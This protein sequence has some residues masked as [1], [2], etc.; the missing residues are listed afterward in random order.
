MNVNLSRRCLSMLL[1]LVMLFTMMPTNIIA[2]EL[3]DHDHEEAVSLVEVEALSVSASAS[4][5]Y[6]YAGEEAVTVTAKIAGGMAPYEV[7]LQAVKNG[8]VVFTDSKTTESN[9]VKLSYKPVSWG[10]YELV[11]TAHDALH[12]QDL[13]T[14]TLAVAEHDMENEAAWAASV[15]G[16]SVSSDWAKSLVSVAKT[17]VGYEES[18]KDFVIKSGEKQG[19]S[20]YGAWFGTPYTGWNNAFL[21]FVAEYAKVPNDA[22]LSGSSYRSWVNGMSAKGAYMKDGYT[23]KAGDIA[24]L[25][26]SRAALVESV[27][28]ANVTVIE[29]DVNGAV[30]RK[31]Y[32]ISKVA[33]FGN[34]GLM[35]GLHNGTATAVPTAAPEATKAPE[36]G[37]APVVTAAPTA[38]PAPT[39]VPEDE[40]LVFQA[41][42]TPRPGVTAKPKEDSNPL[43]NMG[44]AMDQLIG[45]LDAAATAI[46]M[47]FSE[48]YYLMQAEMNALLEKYLGTATPTKAEIEAF[49]EGLELQEMYYILLEIEELREYAS[50]IGISDYEG[51]AAFEASPMFNSFRNTMEIKYEMLTVTRATLYPVE[52]IEVTN[53]TDKGTSGLYHKVEKSFWGSS[54]ATITIKNTADYAATVEFGYTVT[55]DD[56]AT[57][58]YVKFDT[59]TEYYTLNNGGASQS[60]VG[61][62][63]SYMLAAGASITITVYVKSNAINNAWLELY[64]KDFTHT[65]ANDSSKV[66]FIYDE[67]LGLM[68]VA[69]E[70]IGSGAYAEI[71]SAGAVLAATPASG[72]S[73]LGWIDDE[74][75]VRSTETTFTLIPPNEMTVQAVFTKN[76]G[77]STAW[78][79]VGGTHLYN[80]LNVAATAA[81]G[82][83]SKTVVLMNNATLPAGEYTIPAGVTM[84]IPFDAANTLYT[85][86]PDSDAT[87]GFLSAAAVDYIQPTYFR[88]LTME[89][90]AHITIDGAMSLSAKHHAVAGGGRGAGAPNGPVS[91]VKMESGST[92]A[93]NSGA[94]LYAWGFITGAGEV[95]AEAGATVYENFQFEDFRGGTATTNMQS[96]VFPLSHY[97]VQNIECKLKIKAGAQVKTFTSIVMSRTEV[98]L[99]MTFIAG[100]GDSAEAM[101]RISGG[102]VTKQYSGG[103]MVVDAY[104]AT[105]GISKMVISIQG[106][107]LDTSKYNLPI[108]GNVLVRV[109]NGSVLDIRQNIEMHPGATIILDEGAVCNMSGNVYL[110]AEEDWGP[111]SCSVNFADYKGVMFS[112]TTGVKPDDTNVRGDAKVVVN[113]RISVQQLNN[114][115][116]AAVYRTEHG[117][118]I[119]SDGTGEIVLS[120]GT[121]TKTQ[122]VRQYNDNGEKLEYLDIPVYPAW[123]TNNPGA[124]STHEVPAYLDTADSEL[125]GDGTYYYFENAWHKGDAENKAC[126]PGEPA[127]CTTDCNCIFCGKVVEAAYHSIFAADFCGEKACDRC[128]QAV[129]GSKPHVEAATGEV[130]TPATCYSE[131]VMSFTCTVCNQ[132]ARTE[133]VAKVPHTFGGWMTDK[134]ATCTEA[135]TKHREC[136]TC[137]AESGDATRVE[138]G[139]IDAFGHNYNMVIGTPTCAVN[140]VLTFTCLND[141]NHVVVVTVEDYDNN[142]VNADVADKVTAELIESI[143]AKGHVE[144]TPATCTEQAV[145]N[146][147]GEKYGDPLGHL[148]HLTLAEPTCSK[149]GYITVVCDREGCTTTFASID[150]EDSI[151]DTKLVEAVTALLAG[152]DAY[153]TLLDLKTKG[154]S[155]GDWNVT[156]QPTCTESGSRERT[157]TVEGCGYKE[158]EVVS[159]TGHTYIATHNEKPNGYC[160]EQGS[161]TLTC[162]C[163]D[164]YTVTTNVEDKNLKAEDAAW[165]VENQAKTEH[166]ALTTTRVAPTCTAAG[167]TETACTCGYTTGKVHAGDATGHQYTFVVSAPDCGVAGEIAFECINSANGVDCDV[168]G[169]VTSADTLSALE[170]SFPGLSNTLKADETT[171]EYAADLSKLAAKD[172]VYEDVWTVKTPADCENA[173]VEHRFCTNC[174]EGEETRPINALGHEF[175]YVNYV[176]HTEPTCKN[177]AEPAY[178]TYTYKCTNGGCAETVTLSYENWDDE[179]YAGNVELIAALK[180]LDYKDCEASENATAEVVTPAKCEVDAIYGYRCDSCGTFVYTW[181]ESGTALEHVPGTEATCTADQTCTREGC[182]KV[183]EAAKGHALV[184]AMTKVPDCENPGE[185]T[186]SCSRNCG[187]YTAVVLGKDDVSVDQDILKALGDKGWS[188]LAETL[189]ATGHAYADTWTQVENADGTKS[190]KKVCANDENHVL[191]DACAGGTATCEAAAVCT[192][193]SNS[194]GSSLGHAYGDTWTQVENAEGTK[195]H[196]K[197]CANDETHVLM[198]TCAGGTAT[199]E[200]AAVCTVCGNSYGDPLG[201]AYGEWTQTEDGKHHT[202]VCANDNSH[203][204][205]ED[206]YGTDAT[207]EKPA[208]CDVCKQVFVAASGHAYG[209]WT[210]VTEPTCTAEGSKQRVCSKDSTHVETDTI[211]AMGHVYE[212]ALTE[213]K[214]EVDGHITVTCTRGDITGL[215]LN[216]NSTADEQLYPGLT[217]ALADAGYSDLE[218]LLKHQGH[219]YT[220]VTKYPTCTVDGYI[221]HTCDCGHEYTD[222]P[223]GENFTELAK[224]GH[225]YQ[226]V[227]KNPT[228]TVDGYVTVTCTE[229]DYNKVYG[230]ADAMPSN[231]KEETAVKAALGTEYANLA[232]LAATDHAFT[233]WTTETEATC[234]TDGKKVSTCANGCGETAEEFIPAKGHTYSKEGE[235]APDC[236]TPGTITYSCDACEADVEN[237]TFV[238]EYGMKAENLPKNL[239]LEQSE[240]EAL[241]ATGHQNVTKYQ[242][243]AKSCLGYLGYGE[244]CEDCQTWIDEREQL[245]ADCEANTNDKSKYTAATCEAAGYYMYPC[246]WCKEYKF[247]VDDT[248]APAINHANAAWDDGT[249][250]TCE[251]IGYEKGL[252]CPDCETYREGHEEI[253]M[254]DHVYIVTS[255]GDRDCE[256]EGFQ[257]YTCQSGCKDVYE[258]RPSTY[259]AEE[260]PAEITVTAEMIEKLK[261]RGHSFTVKGETVDPECKIDNTG[262]DGYTVYKCEHCDETE[263]KDS[264]AWKHDFNLDAATCTEDKKC[265]S[266]QYVA[267]AKLGHDYFQNGAY[268]EAFCIKTVAAKCE[269]EGYKVYK[270][271]TCQDEKTVTLPALGHHMVDN[272]GTPATCTKEG[273]AAFSECDREGCE[274]TENERTIPAKGHDY[275]Q[276]GAYVE[277]FCTKTVNA[278]CTAD[279]YKVYEC[280]S[281]TDEEGHSQT[282][283]LQKLGHDYEGENNTY[284]GTPDEHKDA[285]CTEEGYDIFICD[286]CDENTEGHSTGKVNIVSATNHVGTTEEHG[287]QDSAC[288]A[289]GY[290]AGVYCTACKTWI[291]GHDVIEAKG[292]S[293]KLV[294]TAPNCELDG[295]IVV[296]CTACNAVN[297]TLNPESTIDEATYEGLTAKVNE[298]LAKGNYASLENLAAL[299]HDWADATCTAPK[300]CKREGCGETEGDKLGH[301]FT[302]KQETIAPDCNEDNTGTDGYTVYKCERCTETDKKDWKKWGHTYSLTAATCVEDRKCSDCGYVIE[303]ALGHDYPVSDEEGW[304][305]VSSATCNE[306]GSMKRVCA[307]NCGDYQT[308]VIPATEH[309]GTTENKDKQE[310][311][312]TEIGYEAGVYCTAC[313][314]WISGHDVIE[315]K[316]H[317]YKLVLTDPTCTADGSIAVS[318]ND[319]TGVMVALTPDSTINEEK[320]EG[321][322]ASVN[323]ALEK[324]GYESLEKL[325]ERGHDWADAT[326]TAPKT[327]QR[328]GCGMTTGTSLGHDW[329]AAT[330]TAPKTCQRE[331]CGVTE[332]DKLDHSYT[333]ADKVT[334]TCRTEGIKLYTCSC[335]DSYEENI[336]VNPDKH[337]GKY[338]PK[339][340]ATCTEPGKEAGRIC[341]ECGITLS[342]RGEI[343]A[344]GHSYTNKITTQPACETEGV[345][346]FTCINGSCGHT[347]TEA[348]P[349]TG[350]T[351]VPMKEVELNCEQNGSKGGKVCSVCGVITEQPV[352][353]ETEGHKEVDDEAVAP[354]C[355]AT[356]LTKGSHCSVCNKTIVEQEVVPANGHVKKVLEAVAPTCKETGLSEG[357]GCENCDVVFK[358]QEIVKATGHLNVETLAAVAPTCESTGLTE[359]SKCKDCGDVLTPQE[360]VPAEGHDWADATCTDPK[361]CKREG[362]GKTE[363]EALGH[364][365]QE[366]TCTDAKVCKVCKVTEGEALG[367]DWADA[368]CTEPKTCK[369][370]KVTEGEKLGHT[371]VKDEAKDATC[372][373]TGLTEGSHCSVCN[374]TLE[375]QNVISAKGH[376]S[377]TDAYQAPTCEATGLKEGSHCSVCNEV[378]VEQEVI[379]A[380]QHKYTG[381]ETKAPTCTEDGVMTYVCENDATHT[382]TETID[383]LGHDIEKHDAQKVTCT[384]IG[385]DAYENCKRE[386]CGYTTYVEIAATG[387]KLD[388]GTVTKQFT[389]TEAG[390]IVYAC[391]NDGCDYTEIEE[392]LA[393]HIAE[394]VPGYAPTCTETGLTEGSKCSVCGEILVKQEVITAT[395]KWE[396]VKVVIEATCTTEGKEDVRCTAEGCGVTSTIITPAKGHTEV[397]DPA[398]AKTCDKDGLTEGKHCSVCKAVLVKQEVVPASHEWS[399][400]PCTSITA[401][402]TECGKTN[403]ALLEH[404]WSDATCSAPATCSY[405]KRTKGSALPHTEV[406]DEEIP[407]MC[408]VTGL[409]AGKH[410]S[411]CGYVIAKQELIPA[412]GHNMEA[413]EAKK[414]TFTSVG[415]EAY[416][417]CTRCA[418]TTQVV[419]PALGEQTISSYSEFMKYL[420][421]LEQFAVAYAKENPGTDPVALVIKYIRTGVDRYNSGSWG[422]M[423]GYENAGFAKY[424]GEQEDILN[425]D[426]ENVEDMIKVTGLKNI[427]EFNLP[428]GQRTDIGHMFG[429]MDITY[430]N[431]GSVNHADVGGWAGDLVDLLSTADHTDHTDVIASAGGDFEKLVDAIR[432]ELLGHSFDHPDTFSKT[433][434]YGDLD[435]FYVM[436]NLDTEE[437]VAGDMTALFNS[438]FTTSLDDVDRAAY[439]MEHRLNGVATRSAVRDAVYT[440]YT[441]NNV[442]STLEGTRD[443]NSSDLTEMRQAVCYAFADYLCALAGDYVDVTDNPYLTVFQSE[444]ANLA[445]GISMEIH[446]ANSADNK[447]M[448]YYL[449]YGAVGR[450]DVTVLANY[451]ERHVTHWEMSRV[452]DQ[453]NTTQDLYSNPENKE[454]FADGELSKNEA[455]LFQENFNVITA[456]NG[457]GFN[458]GTGEP[459]GLLV[460]HGQE[461]HA[462]D[463]NG[464]FGMHKDGY[465]VI[466]TTEEY[467][468]KYKGQIE[469]AI[470]GFGTM[471]VKDGEL[472]ITAETDYYLNRASRTAIGI[473]ATGRVVFMVLDGRQEPWSCGGS[474]IEIA[475]IMKNAGCVQAIN[476]DGGGSTTFVA[477]QAG[478]DELSVVNRPSDGVSRSVSTGL[479]MISTAPSSTAFDHAVLE[480]DYNNA[481]VGSTV[482]MTAKG[483]SATGNVVD[484]P[485]GATWAVSDED[486]GSI[487]EN[488]VFTAKALGSVEV[489][490]VLDGTVLGYKTLNVVTPDQI[491]FTKE[492]LDGVYGSA[493][494]LPL[495]A[496]YEGK[497]VAFNAADIKFTL[498]HEG[499]GTIEGLK[500]KI[501]E[502][503]AI[504]NVTIT[505][506]LAAKSEINAKITVVL[507]KQGENSFDFDQATGG[508]RILAWQRTVSNSKTADNSV[509][510]I[511]DPNEDMVTSYVL[512]LDMTQIPMPARLQDLV[513]MLPGSDMEG[514]CAW[515]FL[516][517]LA[518]RISDLTEVKPQV[519]I[520]PNFDV[521]YSEL[522]VIND[523]FKLNKT[524]FDPETNTLTLTLNWVKQSQPIPVDTANPLCMVTGLKITPKADAK[525]ND[526]DQLK[527]INEG[528]VSYRV[529]MRASG[530]YSFC[531]K[532][533]NQKVFGLQPY[534]HPL[535]ESEKG[536]YF[537]DTYKEFS[538]TYTLVRSMKNG[539]Y[540]EDSGFRYYVDGVYLTGVQKADGLFYDFGEDGVNVGKKTYTGLHQMNGKT[541]Y[542][543]VGEIATGWNIIGDDWYL[544]NYSTGEGLNGKAVSGGIEYEFE[545]GRLLHGVWRKDS[546]GL[547]YYYGPGCYYSGWKVIEGEEY[548]FVKEYALTGTVPVQ[549]AHDLVH[550]WYE[551][552]EE[553]KKVG[554]AKDGLYWYKGERYYVV[555][556]LADR[557]GLYYIDGH[558]YNFTY[559]D[560]ATR[561]QTFWVYVTND[562]GMAEGMYRFGND[563]KMIM[564]TEIVKEDGVLYYYENG[565]RVD[566]KGMV[567]FNNN[568]YYIAGGGAAVVDKLYW[569]SKTNGLVSKTGM[570]LFDENGCMVRDTL[571]YKGTDGKLNYIKDGC[572]TYNAGLV[573]VDGAYYYIQSDGTAVTNTEMYISKTNGLMKAGTYAFGADGKMIIRLAGDAA[574][575]NDVDMDDVLALWAYLAGEDVKISLANADVNADGKIDANDALLI[576]QYVSGWDVTLK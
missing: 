16:A 259:K 487:D 533:E 472:A 489:R 88:T 128:G 196:K 235:Q 37:E 427:T 381:T 126:T 152:Y 102:Y 261:A 462:I 174:N 184:A 477:R 243:E 397:I 295:S 167:Y 362:C 145:C 507:F 542:I 284:V 498:S 165:L 432:F 359:G 6:V 1:V 74:G 319:C 7:T 504:T 465:A 58:A 211:P 162:A 460:M 491:Y 296:S 29:G 363:G 499:V 21:A 543:Q 288:T 93:V 267:Q 76:D 120:V 481:T 85:S 20:R 266:C 299:E 531:Q 200:A 179:E 355:T 461:Y 453:A 36:G 170:Q 505:A 202:Q 525:W 289:I 476:L 471:L 41:T 67:S 451:N 410:C 406:I 33:G 393:H 230:K 188:N 177:A 227:L 486:I 24:F 380:L 241:K 576:M 150:P 30:V 118:T 445:P 343:A 166:I 135:G 425:A 216:W 175:D 84:L 59:V 49:V 495:K 516:L 163:G 247:K 149:D 436:Q 98:G 404:N 530:L 309:A 147:C 474:M 480:S 236:T 257:V 221:T 388:E 253:G 215:V 195:S 456:I 208:V 201:H 358:A 79:Q 25:S 513:Y 368:T 116:P 8:S 77:T 303:K 354:T 384:E 560:Y 496:R 64:L 265:N 314:T 548:F 439:L 185:I 38:T 205:T 544:F 138:N 440:A 503:S 446:Y 217:Q 398:V 554:L 104:N 424:V 186:I 323:A 564:T 557:L 537:T 22:L 452:L 310:P 468:T 529:Y 450:E 264:V 545:N 187:E 575:D 473:T 484:L 18:E 279:G 401:K 569:V 31:T 52:G 386:G 426:I 140:A 286:R 372:T 137:T 301:S 417:A 483:V 129:T 313:K 224:K 164:T 283:T 121:E 444:H 331:G 123:L 245:D 204:V 96:G 517:Q 15:S 429:T 262:T 527:P 302:V 226:A 523:Y 26:G 69:G 51:A 500:Y 540:N 75:F 312:C 547:K 526:K 556:G 325:A 470:A 297:L 539:W 73:F 273:Q 19:Y 94:N 414:P 370:C 207:C 463:G 90:G 441:S 290:E 306:V 256:N 100:D 106:T 182:S 99:P 275:F 115:T 420:P 238:V 448:V 374:V 72:A 263:N 62:R 251:S 209:D 271:E 220:S 3:H 437:F 83:S 240:I 80:D 14:V 369:T 514:A 212:L 4:A 92:I 17:Q 567:E 518:E 552:T 528:K 119:T 280:K 352:I 570:Y 413:H 423:A 109:H 232:A 82:L 12:D 389:C 71:S 376:K 449:A 412:L 387:H 532:E 522:K 193:C 27:S 492:K 60:F 345:K 307:R 478:D 464:F 322:T 538:D 2:E 111:Y 160:T 418:L 479:V 189:K 340:S 50:S 333:A 39:P 317:S 348:V 320:Y 324:A 132:V 395:H 508:D 190:H 285:T 159:A 447:Q 298:E 136:T 488:G 158:T 5:N 222:R 419:I 63:K 573:Q 562:T 353:T 318:C 107:R 254:L 431:N 287:K 246:Y 566:Q 46:P 415:W 172:H 506:E 234:T 34:T 361:T 328:E 213:R 192:V 360:V 457:A 161:I 203:T 375:A 148:Y 143:K 47:Q 168:A 535:H 65:K 87:G 131:G 61:T 258:L 337:T 428:N 281:C 269:E 130:T 11:I 272:G 396:T 57:G 524:E 304:T 351:D 433:D 371:P 248:S 383:K 68:T 377:V 321:L 139:T 467:K 237:H 438:Y 183:L 43:T 515:T 339:E 155:Y 173:G 466:G 44:D 101:F 105:L 330:C 233:T 553:G 274:H 366:A 114:A 125:G 349:A 32:A 334:A 475:Q 469:E 206:C 459:G 458:M 54:S 144:K 250:A 565:P 315:A 572:L 329:A 228:C 385:W 278:T 70:A 311:T 53:V 244:Y 494:D 260:V 454:L 392:V 300:T 292:H 335:G 214:C 35:Q 191:V 534:V 551:F 407:A 490:L 282:V 171:K 291:S 91:Y 229:C 327:C 277:A 142:T 249:P 435:A 344:T 40:E 134:E 156:K 113:G 178:G 305:I 571:I 103:R 198:D 294:L 568:L 108:N 127:S 151:T 342:G 394:V 559:N 403:D 122:Q 28:G 181:P 347:Y 23:P 482:K 382:Y 357:E 336:G 400:A 341:A 519:K 194:Y 409:T 555:D 180:L 218:G 563:G 338:A 411:V 364:K 541:Y 402:C 95:I 511:V 391:V 81:A 379:P 231:E 169:K 219:Q 42:P 501:A 574:G 332:G 45:E 10:D 561:N 510:Y 421:Y 502:E 497:E 399:A 225:S 416:E 408:A 157:C 356:G 442:I 252:W 512:A 56:N 86:E 13:T 112:P 133:P 154:H 239:V 485:E 493:V 520:D 117:S 110:Y 390:E 48:A 197:V 146:T 199:C 455:E 210:T 536:G 141:S 242:E 558:Y 378:L 66:T 55:V 365:W 97:S 550:Y 405:C 316:G 373:E 546:K 521:D 509:Y 308:K 270:C 346:T 9:S 78:W 153:N 89:P 255:S 443:F 268:V 124:V 367:H 326:C 430:H 422:I 276:N 549:E 293:Y 176:A 350:H 434:I 223:D